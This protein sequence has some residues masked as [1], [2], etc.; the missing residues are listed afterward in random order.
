MLSFD[1]CFI[2]HPHRKSLII[3]RD[4]HPFP[5]PLYTYT[6]LY[7]LRRWRV[8]MIP[9]TQHVKLHTGKINRIQCGDQIALP[10]LSI[11]IYTILT[12]T[13]GTWRRM[14]DGEN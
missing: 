13:Q 5:I 1:L 4:P 3:G 12:L 6:I 10:I 11:R 9:V 7:S 8:S 2:V 14:A